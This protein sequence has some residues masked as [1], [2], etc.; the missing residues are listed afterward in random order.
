[1]ARVT[2]WEPV[3]LKWPVTLGRWIP[4]LPRGY[5]DVTAK[6]LDSFRSE[7]PNPSAG[8]TTA[9]Y[10]AEAGFID[11]AVT[12]VVIPVMD[13]AMAARFT[14]DQ[15]LAMARESRSLSEGQIQLWLDDLALIIHT[16]RWLPRSVAGSRRQRKF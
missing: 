16:G 12:A 13:Y 10:L 1:M 14:L 15:A 9:G 4:L 11:I 8:T 3:R 6:V 5:P 7:I 2:S